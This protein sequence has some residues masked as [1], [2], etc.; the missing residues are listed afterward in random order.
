MILEA[1]VGVDRPKSL[2]SAPDAAGRLIL[3]TLDIEEIR[4]ADRERQNALRL[5]LKSAIPGLADSARGDPLD[6]AEEIPALLS[7][8]I[9][10]SKGASIVIEPTRALTAI[11][12]NAGGAADFFQV[13]REAAR[14]IAR[15]LRLRNIGGIV[16]VDFISMKRRDSRNALVDAFRGA[17]DDD[18]AHV[19]MS[20]AM[21]GLGLVELARERRGLGL[22][23]VMGGR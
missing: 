9:S 13:N 22:A 5:W 21:S 7:P 2:Y 19:R 3:D 4:V 17:L 14:V 12:V 15:Q 6:L 8:E 18:P 11:D 16:V 23:E 10:L 20:R 1:A